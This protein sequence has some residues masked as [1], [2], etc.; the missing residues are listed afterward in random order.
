PFGDKFHEFVVRNAHV[1]SEGVRE[2]RHPILDHAQFFLPRP[3]GVEDAVKDFVRLTNTGVHTNRSR[4]HQLDVTLQLV[5]LLHTGS[6]RTSSNIDTLAERHH[7]THESVCNIG[8]NLGYILRRIPEPAQFRFSRIQPDETFKP[9]RSNH[10]THSSRRN[11]SR[12]RDLIREFRPDVTDRIPDALK[13]RANSLQIKAFTYRPREFFTDRRTSNR[14]V[15]S[16]K[17][18]SDLFLRPLEAGNHGHKSRR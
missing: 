9:E 2:S 13:L 8:T 5:A 10:T 3:G 17:L 11:R 1:F 6:H 7:P 4:I 12:L 18:G 16:R 14:R 15:N